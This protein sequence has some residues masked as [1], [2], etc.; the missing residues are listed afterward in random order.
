MPI[1][2]FIEDELNRARE[3]NREKSRL[4]PFAMSERVLYDFSKD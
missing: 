2:E 4:L 1:D 3:Q